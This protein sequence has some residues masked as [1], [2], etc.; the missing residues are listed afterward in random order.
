MQLPGYLRG[1][2]LQEWR[3]LHR[4]EQQDYPKAIEA[5]RARLD[6]GSK[7]MAAQDFRHS[8]QKNGET[9]SDFICRLEKTY[10]IAYGKD[11]LNAATRDALLYG[12][13]YEGLCYD[14][15]LSP[16]VSGAQGYRELCTA[17]KGEERRLAALKQRRQYT[18]PPS[19][20]PMPLRTPRP[21][22]PKQPRHE[23]KQAV[24]V[25]PRTCYNCGKPGH[26]A[27]KCPL[28][29]QESKGRA[30]TSA[31]TKQVRTQSR[32][33]RRQDS[34]QELEPEEFL[35]S[36]SD[37][38]PPV[39][40]KSVRI[41]DKGS[42]TQCVKVQVQGVP[43]YGLIDSGADI[44]IIGGSLFK[45]VATVARLRKRDFMKADKVP[46]TYDQ[47][48]F[49][50]DGRMDLDIVFGEATMTTPVYIKMD[51]HD[52]LLLSE[53]VC[54]QLG[55]LQYHPSLERWRGGKRKSTTESAPE[56]GSTGE[57]ASVDSRPVSDEHNGA[58]VPTVRVNLLQSTQLLPYQSRIVEV[59]VTG[60]DEA[61]GS[62]LLE[63]ALLAC[64]LTPLCY[65]W[66]L[67]KSHWQLS[68]TPQD[69]LCPWKKEVHW[70]KQLQLQWCAPPVVLTQNLGQDYSRR[71]C[72]ATDPV[73]ASSMEEE[74]I[75]GEHQ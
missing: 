68:L 65:M 42:I 9:V 56:D 45:K 13:L 70:E 63:P 30:T 8:L 73:Q 52:Q 11:D 43:A 59:A 12:Q 61:D 29:R 34:T 44:T 22:D 47:R 60:E 64:G 23:T 67:T 28:P 49:Q 24:P 4:T 54:R 74:A 7:T 25:G 20:T 2:A 72:I 57:G 27:M 17:A 16:A 38:D 5:L 33:R 21:Q 37:E 39:Q 31:K 51:A 10:Q 46:R 6:P 62:Y 58:K 32:S 71:G 35:H 69:V 41:T 55:I 19:T 26:F 53:G 66:P 1:R 15:M 48:P 14:V 36:S 18:K 75:S 40:V 50:L 3:L